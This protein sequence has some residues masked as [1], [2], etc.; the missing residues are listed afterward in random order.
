MKTELDGGLRLAPAGADDLQYISGCIR[1][2]VLRSVTPEEAELSETWIDTTMAVAMDSLCN[3]RMDDDVFVLLDGGSA[4]GMLWMGVSRDQYTCEDTGYLL[5]IYVDPDLR[6]RGIG[7]ELLGCA[8]EWCR[9]RGLPS[10]TLDS[11]C[12]NTAARALYEKHGYSVRS[13]IMRRPL[14]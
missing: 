2:S 7:S 6:G 10:M 11:G 14:L 13:E 4:V 3:R 8:E 9:D 12:A 1:E 5:G